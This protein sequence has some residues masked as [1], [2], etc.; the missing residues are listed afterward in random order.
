VCY[1]RVSTPGQK[2]D[3]LTQN[4]FKDTAAV[5]MGMQA[6]YIV[7]DCDSADMVRFAT[8]DVAAACDYANTQLKS[9]ALYEIRRYTGDSYIIVRSNKFHIQ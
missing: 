5:L 6:V 8:C 7:C 2:T 1:C 4:S 9:D 3:T